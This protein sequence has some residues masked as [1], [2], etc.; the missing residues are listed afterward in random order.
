MKRR[1]FPT[2][3]QRGNSP[4]HKRNKK[5]YDYTPMYRAILLRDPDSEFAEHLRSRRRIEA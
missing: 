1:S 5:E 3:K 2:E 4:Y